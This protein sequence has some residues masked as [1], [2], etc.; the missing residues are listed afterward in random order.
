MHLYVRMSVSGGLLKT[1]ASIAAAGSGPHNAQE[2]KTN[3]TTTRHHTQSS[4]SIHAR[5]HLEVWWIRGLVHMRTCERGP[6]QSS[7]H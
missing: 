7:R 4:V 5:T 1:N 3:S 6:Y 2:A